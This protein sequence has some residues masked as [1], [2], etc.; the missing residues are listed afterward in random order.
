MEPERAVVS[1]CAK[2]FLLCKS[3]PE[4]PARKHDLPATPCRTGVRSFCSTNQA[5]RPPTHWI[6]LSGRTS[7][8]LRSWRATAT[9]TS[10]QRLDRCNARATSVGALVV[11]A[12]GNAKPFDPSPVNPADWC[13]HAG[14]DRCCDSGHCHQRGEWHQ[15]Q[16]FVH[17]EPPA[18]TLRQ[19]Y[20]AATNESST[21][22]GKTESR[23]TEVQAGTRFAVRSHTTSLSPRRV[24]TRPF[25]SLADARPQ[26]A[27][28]PT[29]TGSAYFG[30][31]ARHMT[32]FVL[33]FGCLVFGIALRASD[34]MPLVDIRRSTSSSSTFHC[35]H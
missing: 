9:L 28:I 25:L 1:G 23:R 31:I 7:S 13:G 22:C 12:V 33:L 34:R 24:V 4:C 6:T 29:D 18:A 5:A 20:A 11:A 35:R 17:G 10:I 14:P 16:P 3:D 2:E 19:R 32:N 8:G 15:E 27:A 21:S 30:P 26:S